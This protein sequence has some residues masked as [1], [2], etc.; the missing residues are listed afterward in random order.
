VEHGSTD[1][2]PETPE[3]TE[4]AN[5]DVCSYYTWSLAIASPTPTGSVTREPG[6]V[7]SEGST[8]IPST[9]QTGLPSFDTGD[10]PD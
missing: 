10:P 1:L 4:T 5:G 2:T 9:Q 8:A 6:S 7:P 3:S